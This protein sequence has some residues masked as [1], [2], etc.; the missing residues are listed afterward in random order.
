MLLAD[1]CHYI[2]CLSFTSAVNITDSSVCYLLQCMGPRLVNFGIDQ[3][4]QL[5]DTVLIAIVE[6]CEQLESLDISETGITADAIITHLIKRDRLMKLN[7]VKVGLDEQED[8]VLWEF[9][10]N[11]GSEVYEKWARVLG[12]VH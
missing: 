8:D 10:N 11:E 7:R 9:V 3:C 6:H 1:Q 2:K 12:L 5:T 4:S